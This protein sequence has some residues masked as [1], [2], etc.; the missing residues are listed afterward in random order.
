MTKEERE[1]I[2]S[3]KRMVKDASVTLKEL[4]EK[5]LKLEEKVAAQGSMIEELQSRLAA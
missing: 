5:V 4:K 1:E 3:L 2:E